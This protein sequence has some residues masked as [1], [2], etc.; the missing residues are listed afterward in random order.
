MCTAACGAPVGN[1][2]S[3]WR[4]KGHHESYPSAED[5]PLINPS[6]GCTPRA[7]AGVSRSATFALALSIKNCEKTPGNT[8]KLCCSES[9]LLQKVEPVLRHRLPVSSCRQHPAQSNQESCECGAPH[10]KTINVRMD[11]SMPLRISENNTWI[12]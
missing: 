11:S 1:K 7:A 2:C 3:H 9:C 4:C 5:V 8:W 6:V 12:P 10:Q